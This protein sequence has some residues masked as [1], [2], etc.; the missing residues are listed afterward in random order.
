MDD[1]LTKPLGIGDLQKVL[2]QWLPSIA[3]ETT[4][5]AKADQPVDI[6]RIQELV[7]RLI[8]F[9]PTNNFSAIAGFRGA[10]EATAGTRLEQAIASV[11][12]PLEQLSSAR[13][14]CNCAGSRRQKT[15]DF[16]HDQ[17]KPRILAIDDTPP[18]LI[19]LGAAL[20]GDYE[21]QFAS[22]GQEGL[23][24]APEIPAGP[25]PARHHDA[26]HGR[27]RGVPITQRPTRVSA[28]FCHLHYGDVGVGR[29]SQRS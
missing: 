13:H 15:G 8:F 9:W 23:D 17:D 12:N 4:T 11:A 14:S 24:L 28:R 20:T 27:L 18:N 16:H 10:S 7:A 29:R 6:A 25:V 3:P 22:N 1:F 26:G 19:T 21:V 2:G 5:P